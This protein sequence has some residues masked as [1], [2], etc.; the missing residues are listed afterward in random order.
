MQNRITIGGR[1]FKHVE[2]TTLRQDISTQALIQKA[3]LGRLE[4]LQAE[5]PDDYVL[6]ILRTAAGN[7]DVLLLIAHLV[8]PEESKTQDWSPESA[9]E[10]A[11]F[12][13]ALTEKDDKNRIQGLLVNALVS[14]VQAGLVSAVAFPKSLIEESTEDLPQ[15]SNAA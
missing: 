2:E 5:S 14:F 11:T 9:R 15:E 4:L 1:H 8:V 13:G 3:Q 7:C 12:L 6:R 10:V